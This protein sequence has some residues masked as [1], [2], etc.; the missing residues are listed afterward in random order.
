MGGGG[1][2]GRLGRWEVLETVVAMAAQRVAVPKAA[3]LRAEN[4]DGGKFCVISSLLRRK[5]F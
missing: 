1:T 4:G 2:E 3:E 5:T